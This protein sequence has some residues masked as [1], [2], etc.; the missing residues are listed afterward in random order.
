[1]PEQTKPKQ[2]K[3]IGYREQTLTRCETCKHN[4][5]EGEG[6]VLCELLYEW[7]PF[8]SVCNEYEGDLAKRESCK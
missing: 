6:N 8:S 7:V 2:K 1:M 5:C 3:E 4:S